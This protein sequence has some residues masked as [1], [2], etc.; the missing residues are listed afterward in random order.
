ME[1]NQWRNVMLTAL[2]PMMWGTTYFVTTEFLP[3]G[4]PFFSAAMRA[5]PVGLLI[6]LFV[7]QL[8]QS[9]WRWRVLVLGT[10]N[11]GLF[12]PLLFTAAYRL[13]GGIASTVGAI[14]PFVVAIMAYLIIGEALTRRKILAAAAGAVG[15][16]MIV[17]NPSAQF[18][19]IGIAA[20][21]AGTAAMASGTVLTKRWGQPAPLLVFTA[22]QLVAG[23]LILMPLALLIEGLPPA[24]SAANISGFLYLGL[25]GT[26]L[27]YALWL[28]GV[29]HL[30]A[31]T[32]TF[33]TLLSPVTAMTIDFLLLN[34]TLTIIQVIG[35][36][37]VLGAIIAA[38]VT[39][40]NNAASE[41]L[42]ARDEE[43]K[44]PER[45]APVLT[46]IKSGFS[47]IVSPEREFGERIKTKDLSVN[48][49]KILAAK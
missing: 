39:S 21:F 41:N 34:R 12:F 3:P 30:N 27:A 28:R 42:K 25:V 46:Q 17:I 44:R 4:R 45:Q 48:E 37:L 20:A 11:F 22:W 24:L 33:L 14:Q 23:G 26:G 1:N 6:L 31:S 15:V 13:P 29:R 10:L 38:Q 35:A 47:G 19:A 36:V 49:G 7:R 9:V 2:A 18:D 5:L 43:D 40:K 16:G 32:V 8:P